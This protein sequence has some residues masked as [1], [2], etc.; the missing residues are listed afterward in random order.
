[1]IYV[2]DQN[3]MRSEE[4]RDRVDSSDDL[5]VIPDAAFEE[6]VKAPEW[7]DT[8]R[9]SFR[10]LGRSLDRVL[11]TAGMGELLSYEIRSGKPV[12]LEQIVP[13]ALAAASG[14]FVSLILKGDSASDDLIPQVN[15]L[16][17]SLLAG[18]PD[19][20]TQK[21]QMAALK[22]KLAK[23]NG[24]ALTREMRNQRM[25]KDARLGLLKLRAEAL[26]KPH[27]AVALLDAAIDLSR[28]ATTRFYYAT[29][30]QTENWLLNGGLDDANP[31]LLANDAFDLEYAIFGS[32]FDGLLSR[33]RKASACAQDLRLLTSPE[34]DKKM[35]AALEQHAIATGRLPGPPAGSGLH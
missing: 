13:P 21:S 29:L 22:M 23:T 20:A 34:H 18:R 12:E 15:E 9:N 31:N 7:K 10:I 30:W 27:L 17:E 28:L 4:L 8:I 19:G 5:F 33:D 11:F 35:I 2:L 26:A 3:Y 24:S 1:M 6:M 14:L 32:F 16:R 25:E